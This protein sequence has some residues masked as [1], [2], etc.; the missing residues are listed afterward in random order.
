M[1]AAVGGQGLPIA[2]L[3]LDEAESLE[4]MA[5]A[6]TRLHSTLMKVGRC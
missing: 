3:V 6:V 2:P 5:A 4:A 1:I